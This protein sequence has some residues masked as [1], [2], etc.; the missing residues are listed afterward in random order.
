MTAADVGRF[1]LIISLGF[2]AFI[3][4]ISLE[5]LSVPCGSMSAPAIASICP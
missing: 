2:L 1:A 5:P 3:T 4:F